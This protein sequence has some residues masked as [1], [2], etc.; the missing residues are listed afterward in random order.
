SNIDLLILQE[1][2]KKKIINII[3][4]KV[5]SLNLNRYKEAAYQAIHYAFFIEKAFKAYDL[6]VELNPIV[7]SGKSKKPK[8]A[9]RIEINGLSVKWITYHIDD[10]GFVHFEELL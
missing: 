10:T 2:D 8:E 4:L 3:E 9:S 5:K 1:N 6:E 7:L